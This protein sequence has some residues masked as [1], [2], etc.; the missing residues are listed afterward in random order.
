MLKYNYL[1]QQKVTFKIVNVKSIL[2]K[3]NAT[4][5]VA[6]WDNI[7]LEEVSELSL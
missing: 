3:I 4:Y 2:I 1:K 6:T 5:Q 7:L